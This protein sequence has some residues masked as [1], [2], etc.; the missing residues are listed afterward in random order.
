MSYGGGKDL[1]FAVAVVVVVTLD[2]VLWV[3]GFTP[4]LKELSTAFLSAPFTVC[5][6]LAKLVREYVSE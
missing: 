3:G 5:A 1:V 6:S 4:L 2:V